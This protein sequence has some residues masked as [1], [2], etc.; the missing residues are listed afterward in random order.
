M[1]YTIDIYRGR[2]HPTRNVFHFFAYL[3]LFPQLVAGPI[4]R[5]RDL[6]PQLESAGP[7]TEQQRWDGLKL[8]V[9]GYFKKVV[10]ADTLAASVNV[11]FAAST[12]ADSACDSACYWWIIMIMF[13]F[14]ILCDFSGYSDIAR[15]L[16]KWM[17]YEFPLNFDH[18][19]TAGSF[20]EFWQKWHIS[21]STWFRD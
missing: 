16:G 11:A 13:A 15:G 7:L 8:I 3:S 14:Q 17:G 5:A 9:F 10:V 20:R 4:V 6:L 2:L 19:Y 1:S 18:P 12:P 21:L